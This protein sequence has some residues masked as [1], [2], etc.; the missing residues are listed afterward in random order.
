LADWFQDPKVEEFILSRHPIGRI[1]EP[2]EI[3]R[4]VCCSWLRTMPPLLS[5]RRLPSMAV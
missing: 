4:A 1:A 5:A 2:E 3:G